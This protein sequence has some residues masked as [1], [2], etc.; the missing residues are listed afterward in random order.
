MY[1]RQVISRPTVQY[2]CKDNDVNFIW[3]VD[4]ACLITENIKILVEIALL[5]ILVEYSLL[6]CSLDAVRPAIAQ[7]ELPELDPSN[8]C[9]KFMPPRGY[10]YDP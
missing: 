1:D 8:E 6:R 7:K 4:Q 5:K 10:Q 3:T 2:W 9:V